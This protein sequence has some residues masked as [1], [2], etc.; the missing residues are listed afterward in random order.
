MLAGSQT[1]RLECWSGNIPAGGTAQGF[2]NWANGALQAAWILFL[3][4]DKEALL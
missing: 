4:L 1:W 3:T 2:F